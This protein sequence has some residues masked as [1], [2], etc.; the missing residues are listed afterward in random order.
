MDR[1]RSNRPRGIV[2]RLSAQPPDRLADRKPVEGIPD[3]D[4]ARNPRCGAGLGV[5]WHAPMERSQMR[6]EPKRAAEVQKQ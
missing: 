2:L 3:L 5:E 1:S 6:L 4:F